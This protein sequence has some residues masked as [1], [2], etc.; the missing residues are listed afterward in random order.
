MCRAFV[1]RIITLWKQTEFP[2]SK[3]K[4]EALEQTMS[5]HTQL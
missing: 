4:L 5:P 2:R 1:H 3:L